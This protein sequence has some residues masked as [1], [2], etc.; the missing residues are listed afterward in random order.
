MSNNS[1]VVV[2]AGGHARLFT[3]EPAALPELES[4][5]NLVP[6]GE[7]SSALVGEHGAALWSDLKTGRNRSAVSGAAH[8]YDDHRERH[9]EEYD[10]RFAQDVAEQT[11]RLL[12]GSQIK[13]VVLVAQG[14]SLNHLRQAF[15]AQF[16]N[17]TSLVELNKDLGR[18]KPQ[19]IQAHLA[20]EHLVPA[21]CSPQRVAH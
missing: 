7:I 5:P 3:L 2:C 9:A 12:V 19:E 1:C 18:M 11:R 10:R 4:G 20:R 14:N 17:G 16:H 13:H 8:G 15:R 21:R 6:R